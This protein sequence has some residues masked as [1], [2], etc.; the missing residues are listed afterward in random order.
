M[1]EGFALD[2][3]R[4]PRPQHAFKVPFGTMPKAPVDQGSSFAMAQKLGSVVPG[5][6]QYDVDKIE[7]KKWTGRGNAFTKLSREA[8]ALQRNFP[9]VGHYQTAGAMV[10]TSPRIPGGMLPKATKG[11]AL[12][13]T[14]VRKSKNIPDPGKYN[15]TDI[16]GHVQSLRFNPPKS[17]SKNPPARVP[18]GPG[19]YEPNFDIGE[20]SVPA[21]TASKEASK[22]HL[23]GVQKEKAKIPAP[24]FVGIP[25]PKNIDRKGTFKHT[26][27][28]LKDR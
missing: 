6:G 14:A 13:D 7:Q 27:V 23:D 1:P 21:Y 22:S 19:T 17:T 11:C 26:Q 15:P 16:S 10:L 9:A 20:P 8:R 25:D 5:P 18:P 3:Y 12:V 28:L 2:E 4:T 24:G